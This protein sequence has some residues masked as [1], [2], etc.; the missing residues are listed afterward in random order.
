MQVE[1]FGVVSTG[2]ILAKRASRCRVSIQQVPGLCREEVCH[3]FTTGL[4]IGSAE[5]NE[6]G[7]LAFDLD[8]P[9]NL[10]EKAPDEVGER[11]KVVDPVTPKCLQLAVRNDDTAET[12]QTSTD[13]DG[14][15][16]SCEVFVRRICSN[17]LTNRGVEELVDWKLC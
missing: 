7:W 5:S 3:V 9:Q 15:H 8:I 11:I 1:S 12:D 2:R 16:D 10:T 4:P 13:Q 14:I 17:C 6:F